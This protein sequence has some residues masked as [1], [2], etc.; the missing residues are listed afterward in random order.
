MLRGSKAENTRFWTL[1]RSQDSFKREL[2]RLLSSF[3]HPAR[4]SLLVLMTPGGR[5][6]P[7]GPFAGGS[8]FF[9]LIFRSLQKRPQGSPWAQKCSQGLQNASKIDPKWS[10]VGYQKMCSSLPGS[11]NANLYETSL[12]IV[13]RQGLPLPPTIVV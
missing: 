10:P 13:F 1:R 3:R 6:L 8:P 4:T 5:P 7:R 11:K 2:E 9:K 12:F